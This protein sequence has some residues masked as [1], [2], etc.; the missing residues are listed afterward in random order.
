MVAGQPYPLLPAPDAAHAVYMDDDGRLWLVDLT[1][2]NERQLAEGTNLSRLQMWG[3]AQ[4]LLVGVY[5][6]AAEGEGISTGHVATLD[7]VSGDIQI[8]DEEYLSLGRPAMAPDGQTIAYDVSAF[9]TDE[10]NGRIYQPDRGSQPLNPD[11]FDGLEGERPCN[12]FNPAWSPDSRQIAW[13]CSSEAG[14]RLIVFDLVRRTAM[15]VFT[16]QPAQFGALPPSPV[17]SID[18]KWL[19]IE[20]W[21]NNEDESGLWV[22][23]ADGTLPRLN[24][25][26]GHE[27]I[28]L[29][30]TQLIYADLDENMNGD[31]KLF[32]LDYGETNVLDLPAGSSLLLVPPY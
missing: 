24:V 15:T 11:L 23:P 27:P 2:G 9:S 3:N 7:I 14:S 5:L 28:W 4:T 19:A 26:T 18:G 16:W 13:L 31:I 29:N 32:D 6:S 17:W 1:D 22:L 21:A 10:I 8:F 30:P 20:I 25:P 12:L